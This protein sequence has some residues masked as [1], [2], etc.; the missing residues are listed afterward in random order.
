MKAW[1][2]YDIECYIDEDSKAENVSGLVHAANYEDAVNQVSEDYGEDALES[3]KLTRVEECNCLEFTEIVDFFE[4]LGTGM[5]PEVI[6]DLIAR[7]KEI[8]VND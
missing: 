8:T 4:E 7:A 5:P 6:A 1:Y 2:K 3:I